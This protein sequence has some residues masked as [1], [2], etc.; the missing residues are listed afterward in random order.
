M[1]DRALLA[2]RLG[3]N[4]VQRVFSHAAQG[5]LEAALPEIATSFSKAAS[6][7]G[8]GEVIAASMIQHLTP[9]AAASVCVIWML[10]G[11]RSPAIKALKDAFGA[12][13]E[14]DATIVMLCW[15]LFGPAITTSS[16]V[17]ATSPLGPFTPIEAS[18]PYR[19]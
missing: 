10:R 8:Q 15:R 12:Q 19:N 5:L 11:A 2:H 3:R 18:A 17:I 13:P 7:Q 1:I 16:S 14:F 6:R 9:K 4:D